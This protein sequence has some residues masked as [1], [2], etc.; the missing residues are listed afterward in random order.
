M[1]IRAEHLV[2]ITHRTA[3]DQV[4]S[5]WYRVLP[6]DDLALITVRQGTWKADIV[7]TFT[8]PRA[9]LQALVEIIN[10]TIPD[11]NARFVTSF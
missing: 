5:A 3:G 7:Y 10:E 9:Y 8:A 2:L 6:E 11:A 4:V 1:T